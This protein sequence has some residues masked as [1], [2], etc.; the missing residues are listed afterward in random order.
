M[1]CASTSWVLAAFCAHINSAFRNLRFY[2]SFVTYTSATR[3]S[4][5]TRVH[6]LM[7]RTHSLVHHCTQHNTKLVDVWKVFSALSIAELFQDHSLPPL[8]AAHLHPKCLVRGGIDSGSLLT[9]SRKK[10]WCLAKV[11]QK[12]QIRVH[13]R[14]SAAAVLQKRKRRENCTDCFTLQWSDLHTAACTGII[15]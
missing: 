6:C 1:G 8:P 13:N 2:S 4:S 11:G 12:L 9:H 5:S 14:S 10:N 3:I 7:L 15:V